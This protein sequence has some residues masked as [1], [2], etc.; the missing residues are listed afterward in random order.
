MQSRFLD[1]KELN[2]LFAIF[3][4]DKW[5]FLVYFSF[6]SFAI[7]LRFFL[8]FSVIF[9]ETIFGDAHEKKMETL[10][11]TASSPSTVSTANLLLAGLNSQERPLF[12]NLKLET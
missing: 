11:P 12:A 6:F 7:F 2:F 4:K 10:L 5:C 1:G 9:L 3:S 8:F